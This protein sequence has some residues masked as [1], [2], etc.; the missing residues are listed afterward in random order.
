[1][2]GLYFVL[3]FGSIGF[4][5]RAPF[6]AWATIPPLVVLGLGL[7]SAGRLGGSEGPSRWLRL[8]GLLLSYPFAAVVVLSSAPLRQL[9]GGD[10]RLPL[11]IALGSALAFVAWH[12]RVPAL[13]RL[14][15]APLSAA[16]AVPLAVFASTSLATATSPEDALSYVLLSF[17]AVLPFVAIYWFW[18]GAN[19]LVGTLALTDWALDSARVLLSGRTLLALSFVAWALEIALSP[20]LGLGPALAES[21][22][23]GVPI[24]TWFALESHFAVPVFALLM[25]L[26]LALRRSLTPS[27]L[28]VVVGFWLVSYL[29]LFAHFDGLSGLAS[30]VE[31]FRLVTL[32][33]YIV[34]VTWDL[35]RGGATFA[36]GDGAWFPRPA[37]VSLYF[38]GMLVVAGISHLETVAQLP[39]FAR[40]ASLASFH[41]ALYLGVPLLGY[42]VLARHPHFASLSAGVLLR[43]LAAGGAIAVVGSVV[44]RSGLLGASA[45]IA[46]VAAALLV[47]ESL[48]MAALWTLLRRGWPSRPG[49]EALI[50]AA[51]LG[52]GAATLVVYPVAIIPFVPVSWQGLAQGPSE[53]DIPLTLASY[54]SHLGSAAILAVGLAA[55]GGPATAS[56]RGRVLRAVTATLFAI[57]FRWLFEAGLSAWGDEL[58]STGLVWPLVLAPLAAVAFLLLWSA[59][60]ALPKGASRSIA[61]GGVVLVAVSILSAVVLLYQGRMLPAPGGIRGIE[62]YAPAGWQA[63]ADQGRSQLGFTREY[64]FGEA[65]ATLAPANAPSGTRLADLV[66]AAESGFTSS[67]QAFQVVGRETLWSG[68]TRVEKRS[69]LWKEADAS[70]TLADVRALA[71]YLDVE[72]RLLVLWASS[73][74]GYE[75]ESE[76]DVL[77]IAKSVQ[78]R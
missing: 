77:R 51:A 44:G 37:R 64:R 39:S 12:F 26:A 25:T 23:W 13:G 6:S 45:G 78:A 53:W 35:M 30:A 21:L 59:R 42:S 54:G 10:L 20:Q 24:S 50:S 22:G 56:V 28:E 5:A 3:Y 75:R 65:A 1:V 57:A 66:A 38:G 32:A 19:A 71:C 49:T 68:S 61:W 73:T 63:T 4:A 47:Q 17:E 46:A 36:N 15:V 9:V 27:R 72:G 18:L 55:V 8:L 52:F 67:T 14:P 60:G 16:V 31:P 74:P 40:E 48:K 11:G 58:Y 34:G 2:V 69:Y 70:G 29:V 41:G 33:V 76:W 7:V 43:M 62:A